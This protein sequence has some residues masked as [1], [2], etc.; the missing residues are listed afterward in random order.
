MAAIWS[1]SGRKG[2]PEPPGGCR[3]PTRALSIR[4]RHGIGQ[5]HDTGAIGRRTPTAPRIK[6]RKPA[7][8]RAKAQRWRDAVAE[9]V[10]LQEDYRGWLEALPESLQES[11]TADV[12]RA[13]TEIDSC[14]PIL[15]SRSVYGT[16]H[17][18]ERFR[19]WR[20][21]GT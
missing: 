2:R 5:G 9:L 20:S 7:D 12:L 14:L 6:Y 8:R 19:G 13:I 1:R 11:A 16:K 3:R 4:L 10:T 17:E 15:F 18:Q 21:D